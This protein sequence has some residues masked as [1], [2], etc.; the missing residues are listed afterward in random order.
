M[1]MFEDQIWRSEERLWLEGPAA[2]GELL[3]ELCV[4][5][6][7]APVGILQGDAIIES[8]R[9]V[10]RWQGVTMTDKLLREPN[11]DTAML[12]YKAEGRRQGS[13][14]YHAY[15]SSSYV[16]RGDRWQMTH[17]QQTPAG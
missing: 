17:H 13:P 14:P 6:F 15:C 7:P 10:P 2:Y 4:M 1:P 16:R 8:L 9:G 3:H 11:S 12:A 5:V